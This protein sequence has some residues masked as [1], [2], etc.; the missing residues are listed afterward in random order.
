VAVILEGFNDTSRLEDAQ[1][2]DYYLDL[3]KK[4][5]HTYDL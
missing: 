1:L 3:F 5:W 2:S 4:E